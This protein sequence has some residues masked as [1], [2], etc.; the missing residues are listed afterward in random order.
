MARYTGLNRL[1]S[2]AAPLPTLGCRSSAAR[3]TKAARPRL[4]LFAATR[5]VLLLMLLLLLLV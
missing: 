1:P 2:S 5:P 3:H 4:L